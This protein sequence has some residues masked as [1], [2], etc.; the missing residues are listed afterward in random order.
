ML[1]LRRIADVRFKLTPDEH[2]RSYVLRGWKAKMFY[3]TGVEQVS[4][5]ILILVITTVLF[6]PN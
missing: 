3:R 4:Q 1:E 5:G 6:S 2:G